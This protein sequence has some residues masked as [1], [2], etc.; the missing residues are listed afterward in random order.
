M[1]EQS[2]ISFLLAL[3]FGNFDLAAVVVICEG[4][5]N[6]CRSGTNDFPRRF[7]SEIFAAAEK[8]S[9]IK[10]CAFWNSMKSSESVSI[11]LSRFWGLSP[12]ASCSAVLILI[13]FFI[14]SHFVSVNGLEFGDL[15]RFGVAARNGIDE[16]GTLLS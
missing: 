13:R 9:F 14:R 11:S 4:N 12:P 3:K 15:I 16:T 10:S 7:F 6:F 5:E 1:S 2:T 8:P